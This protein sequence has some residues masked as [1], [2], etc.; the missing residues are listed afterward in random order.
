MNLVQTTLRTDNISL[1][2]YQCLLG[3]MAFAAQVVPRAPRL[4]VHNLILYLR[5]IYILGSNSTVQ[6][7]TRLHQILQWWT[8]ASNLQTFTPFR[9]RSL[10]EDRCFSNRVWSSQLQE[11][12][13]SR[14]MDTVSKNSPYK[15]KRTLVSVV[16]PEITHFASSS[17]DN[18]PCRQSSSHLLPKELGIKQVFNSSRNNRTGSGNGC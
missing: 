15:C 17:L 11:S 8:K 1:H 18:P 6:P 10:S 9:S 2:D 7:A 13:N 14:S 12:I 16:G 5:H 3:K 4:Q